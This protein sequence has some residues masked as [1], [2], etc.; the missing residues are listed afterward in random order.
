MKSPENRNSPES[1]QEQFF[2]TDEIPHDYIK[3]SIEDSGIG[4]KEE[5]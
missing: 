3:I 5:E 1:I 2:I 4:M